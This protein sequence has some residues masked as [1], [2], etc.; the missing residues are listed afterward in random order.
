M[1]ALLL[2][3]LTMSIAASG[4]LHAQRAAWGDFTRAFDAAARED[5]VVGGSASAGTQLHGS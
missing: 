3:L 4:P 2:I 5:G 1:R